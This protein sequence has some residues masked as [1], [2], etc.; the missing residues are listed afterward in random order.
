MSQF[1]PLLAV[2]AI[3]PM[4]LTG[5]A[6]LDFW[7]GGK[8]NYPTASKKKPA[9]QIITMWKPAKGKGLKGRPTR[10]FAGQVMFFTARDAIP[11]VVNGKV[12]VYLFD[13]HGTQEEQSKPIHQ[14]DFEPEA[15]NTH[16]EYSKL[17]PAYNIFIPYTRSDGHEVDCTLSIRLSPA[18]GGPVIF[19][20]EANIT[21]DG[22][23]RKEM[24]HS[25]GISGDQRR[26]RSAKS[27]KQSYEISHETIVPKR[28]K[29]SK[30]EKR[31]NRR[32]RDAVART[33]HREAIDDDRA[34]QVQRVNYES[35]D[36]DFA[37]ETA[38]DEQPSSR[39][40][41]TSRRRTKRHPLGEQS[42]SREGSDGSAQE[43][44]GA[45]DRLIQKHRRGSTDSRYSHSDSISVDLS[46]LHEDTDRESAVPRSRR[47]RSRPVSDRHPLTEQDEAEAGDDWEEI[48]ESEEEN[49]TF[50]VGINR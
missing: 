19:S 27:V 40:R 49:R 15:W 10:G 2:F 25:R 6:G 46:D 12:R 11:A 47:D 41:R 42:H 24:N 7:P 43:E 9:T 48:A 8:A 26:K 37:D 50:T 23:K 22:P 17:G 21:L 14:F 31:A 38:F 32:G 45:L 5:C 29:F 34:S 30:D 28:V 20:E 35:S 39:S 44:E 33:E 1:K 18:D 4:F 3:L 13:N 16:A 36:G